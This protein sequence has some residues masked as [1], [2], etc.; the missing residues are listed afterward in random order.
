[1]KISRINRK[2]V[3]LIEI[4]V[5]LCIIM[6][7]VGWYIRLKYAGEIIEWENGIYNWVGLDPE[8]ARFVIGSITLIVLIAIALKRRLSRRK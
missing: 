4:V 1:M 7:V 5:V 6:V 3:T 2:G 8:L